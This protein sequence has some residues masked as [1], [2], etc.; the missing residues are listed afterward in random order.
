MISKLILMLPIL[1]IV[2]VYEI[3]MKKRLFGFLDVCRNRL[4]SLSFNQQRCVITMQHCR[5]VHLAG[6]DVSVSSL[7]LYTVSFQQILHFSALS[8]YVLTLYQVY[9]HLSKDLLLSPVC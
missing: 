3:A 5:I 6:D 7:Y 4:K 2:V 8:L 1:T 9:Q